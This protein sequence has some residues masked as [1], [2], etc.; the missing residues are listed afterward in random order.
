M[1]GA[2]TP[3]AVPKSMFGHLYGGAFGTDVLCAAMA[4]RH[5]V[6]PPTWGI[7]PDTDH[8]LALSSCPRE[9]PVRRVLV[10]SYSRYGSCVAMVVATP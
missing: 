5:G 4:V 1:F 3:V 8:P 6:V 9:L 7:D 2:R 10:T